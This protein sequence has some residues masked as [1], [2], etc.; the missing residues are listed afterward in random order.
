MII[1]EIRIQNFKALKDV[2][3]TN[4][5]GMA[6]FIGENGSGKSTFFHVFSFLRDCLRMG[7][8]LALEKEGGLRG[9]REVITRGEA[10]TE[11]IRIEI[12][13]RAEIAGASRLVSY[14]L[15]I[16]LDDK[17]PVVMRETLGTILNPSDAPL[18]LIDFAMGK[19]SVIRNEMEI[20]TSA[21][22]VEVDFHSIAPDTLAI[23]G[24]GMLDRFHTAQQVR[25]WIAGWDVSDFG[26]EL[27]LGC[28][29]A[30]GGGSGG[31]P[32]DRGNY[33]PPPA[34]RG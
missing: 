25:S 14:V 26:R 12:R 31:F 33:P 27:V 2:H 29:S 13:F 7:V 22:E 32:Q 23:A 16:G 30:P 11:K 6:V 3:L 8:R 18:P 21:A 24:L 9:F 15:E 1:E 5:P 19:G 28:L 17:K 20:L 4:L 10:L 34:G